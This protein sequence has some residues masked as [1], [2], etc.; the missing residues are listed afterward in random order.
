MSLHPPLHPPLGAARPA[1]LRCDRT[2]PGG[3]DDRPGAGRT[4]L[5]LVHALALVAA[6]AV[7]S[8]VHVAVAAVLAAVLLARE[9]GCR[10][11]RRSQRAAG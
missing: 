8:A 9:A 10:A 4:A 11:V 7:G 1:P 3:A 2:T 6:V 5:L